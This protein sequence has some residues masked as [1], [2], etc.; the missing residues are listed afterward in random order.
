MTANT[1]KGSE[2][3]KTGT[4]MNCGD[5]REIVAHGLCVKCYRRKE[6]ADDRQAE[7]DR[8]N[9]GI[10]GEHKKLLRGFTSVMVGLSDLGAQRPDVIAIRQMLEPYVALITELLAAAPEAKEGRLLVNSEPKSE[11]VFTAHKALGPA[12]ERTNEV[13]RPRK[14][15]GSV[16]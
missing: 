2:M 10:H 6:R 11:N 12:K 5:P 3:R 9:P 13:D 4:S 15:G 16:K 14:A 8:H 7:V 1:L